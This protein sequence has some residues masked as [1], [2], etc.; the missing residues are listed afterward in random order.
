[1]VIDL[2]G[3]KE[4]LMKNGFI[5]HTMET[6]PTGSKEILNYIKSV[7]GFLPS[8]PAAI[9]E[10]PLA[11]TTFVQSLNAFTNSH[12][13]PLEREVIFLTIDVENRCYYCVAF[14][15]LVSTHIGMNPEFLEAL[16]AGQSPADPKLRILSDMTR[17]LV[18]NKG[19]VDP[20]LIKNFLKAGYS[21]ENIFEIL[22]AWSSQVISN[23]INHLVE[24]PLDAPFQ[25]F[26]WK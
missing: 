14:H 7:Q 18:R 5:Q 9:A 20:E 24:A 26:E 16:R 22:V 10:S 19:N 8:L 21:R 15:S 3:K 11:L 2:I 1:M 6:A 12:F 13:T 4:C 17:M 25:K 23:T